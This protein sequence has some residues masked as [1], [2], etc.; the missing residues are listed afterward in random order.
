ML[1]KALAES[2][3]YFLFAHTVSHFRQEFCQDNSNEI[4]RNFDTNKK[5]DHFTGKPKV[6]PLQN[7][8]Q[9]QG[10]CRLFFDSLL[11]STPLTKVPQRAQLAACR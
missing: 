1:A 5:E 8:C 4:I 11:V 3:T 2:E 10:K 7:L 9:G 6:G